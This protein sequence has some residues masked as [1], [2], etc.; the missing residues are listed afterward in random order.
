MTSRNLKSKLEIGL[1][2]VVAASILVIAV[3]VVKRTFFP[4]QPTRISPQEQAELL[5][6]T[7]MTIP[8]TA[9]DKK[10]LIFFLKKDCVYCQSIAPSYRELIDD[11]KRRN[12]SLIAILPNSVEEGREYVWSLG[13]QIEDVQTGLLSSYKIPGTPTVLFVDGQA[14]V[15]SAWFGAEPGREK[16]MREKLTAL[17]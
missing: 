10:T 17:F 3:V 2:V 5:V 8:G 11:A 12:I 16:E 14:V 1:N 15:R 7:R 9:L 6:G 13:L 4:A